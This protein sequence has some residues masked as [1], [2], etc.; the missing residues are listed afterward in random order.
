MRSCRT[1]IMLSVVLVMILASA[2]CGA[3]DA[4]DFQG[5]YTLVTVNGAKLPASVPVD[6]A[7]RLIQS[8]SASLNYD[9]SVSA[10]LN[11]RQPDGTSAKLE[12]EGSFEVVPLGKPVGRFE[13]APPLRIDLKWKGQGTTIAHLDG[14]TLTLDRG[15]AKYA[16]RYEKPVS[17]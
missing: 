17:R 15:G 14:Q 16:Y 3:L 9:G 1:A 10:V 2:G 5:E 7:M 4:M 8:G 12:S 13:K 6:G 11:V